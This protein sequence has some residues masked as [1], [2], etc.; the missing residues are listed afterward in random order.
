MID[1]QQNRGGTVELAFSTFR[2]FFPDVEPFAGSRRRSHPL[3]DVLGEAYTTY[4]ET[5]SPED[6]DTQY[7]NTLA[8]EWVITPRLNAVSGQE[9]TSWSEYRG[10]AEYNGDSFSLTVRHSPPVR[11]STF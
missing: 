5:L 3:G 8:D 11:G 1:L 2:R 6:E 9:F 7:N 4:F 10:S